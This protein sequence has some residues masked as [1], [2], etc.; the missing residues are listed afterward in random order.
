LG[1]DVLEIENVVVSKPLAQLVR[2]CTNVTRLCLDNVVLNAACESMITT[3]IVEL[4]LGGVR[5]DASLFVRRLAAIDSITDLCLSSG[6]LGL[7]HDEHIDWFAHST[8]LRDVRLQFLDDVSGEVLNALM[9]NSTL[10]SLEMHCLDGIDDDMLR[11]AL[12]HQPATNRNL[13]SLRITNS[14]TLTPSL[15]FSLATSLRN[16]NLESFSIDDIHDEIDA[17]HARKLVSMLSRQTALVSLKLNDLNMVPRERIKL[18]DAVA[19]L[20]RLIELHIQPPD[21]DCTLTEAEADA[22]LRIVDNSKRLQV[23][24]VSAW[25]WPETRREAFLRTVARRHTISTVYSLYKARLDGFSDDQKE[26][27]QQRLA[28]HSAGEWRRGIWLSIAR[29][30]LALCSLDWPAY[31]TLEVLDQIEPI[32]FAEH[33]RKIRAIVLVKNSFRK[34]TNRK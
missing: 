9:S 23:F 2:K 11:T 21:D 26:W 31:V 4:D 19:S 25:Q 33:Q 8:S 34:K 1:E 13:R 5:K 14:R 18:L 22:F 30:C 12:D 10:T 24:G 15:F 27:L 3:K 20:T 29:F 7:R 32:C 16:V 17:P 6:S 28:E